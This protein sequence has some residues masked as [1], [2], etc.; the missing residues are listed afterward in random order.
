MSAELVL[1][2]I[3]ILAN[4]K[5]F[6]LLT[7]I[8]LSIAS[9]LVI[10]VSILNISIDSEKEESI[11]CLKFSGKYFLPVIFLLSFICCLIPSPYELYLIAGT[12]YLNKTDIPVKV[13]AAINKKLD[14]FLN[15]E[16]KSD[17]K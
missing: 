4:V 10:V 3:S 12:H 6:F 8:L 14:E 7:T 1:Y 15:E 2:L 13:E 11:K 5:F 17:D 16:G 9:F